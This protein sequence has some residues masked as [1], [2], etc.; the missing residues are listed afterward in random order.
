MRKI[1]RKEKIMMRK[2]RA[3]G[4]ERDEEGREMR[5]GER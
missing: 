1:G 5:K 2:G 3:R 4:R